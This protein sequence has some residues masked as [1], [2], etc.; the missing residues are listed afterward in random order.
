MR[1][2]TGL[3]VLSSEFSGVP[4]VL[5]GVIDHPAQD[6]QF[7]ASLAFSEQAR[8]RN[9]PVILI[10]ATPPDRG[11]WAA[12]AHEHKGAVIVS[13]RIPDRPATFMQ[14]AVAH[15]IMNGA[16]NVMTTPIDEPDI[17]LIASEQVRR[18]LVHTDVV[19]VGRTQEA[20]DELPPIQQQLA[21]LGGWIVEQTHVLP[22]DS[23]TGP[24]GYN[25]EAAQLLVRYPSLGANISGAPHLFEAPLMIRDAE[26]RLGGVKATF[27]RPEALID[28]EAADP[29]DGLRRY[30]YMVDLFMG[31]MRDVRSTAP[32]AGMIG[33]AVLDHLSRGAPTTQ[34]EL[35][36]SIKL[37]ASK[38]VAFG[39]RPGSAFFSR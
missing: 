1:T 39:F 38:M 34:G 23:L 31:L 8:D 36:R 6:V 14:Q 35:T 4:I 27:R 10:D 20:R 32:R 2:T 33:T 5:A 26:K 28:Q 15:A 12:N 25:R 9:I 7:E 29:R 16:G 17:P 18:A 22:H 11:V 30:D 21:H 3:P 37:L 13:P 24:R 19:I